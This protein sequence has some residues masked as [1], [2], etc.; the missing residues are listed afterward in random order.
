MNII[1]RIGSNGEVREYILEEPSY[2]HSDESACTLVIRI[3]GVE[4]DRRATY[5]IDHKQSRQ[6]AA[7]LREVILEEPVTRPDAGA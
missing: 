5:G 2:T 4:T 1:T 7:R 3:D 6:L